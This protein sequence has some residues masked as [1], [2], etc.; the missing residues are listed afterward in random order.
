MVKSDRSGTGKGRI[1]ELKFILSL[2]KIVAIL[3]IEAF[4]QMSFFHL[5][6]AGLPAAPF[7]CTERPIL[8]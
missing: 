5:H 7:S 4:R 8:F 1:K 6:D 3:N 2:K